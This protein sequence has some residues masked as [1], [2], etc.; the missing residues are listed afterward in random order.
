MELGRSNTL[1]VEVPHRE[2]RGQGQ[3]RCKENLEKPS[4]AVAGDCAAKSGLG[5]FPSEGPAHV[6]GDDRCYD[7]AGGGRPGALEMARDDKE[8]Q[9]RANK[10]ELRQEED[11]IPHMRPTTPPA[12]APVSSCVTEARKK[13]STNSELRPMTSA[14]NTSGASVATSLALRS[15]RSPCSPGLVSPRTTR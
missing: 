11:Q 6:N 14:S 5:S 13:P 10:N 15:S 12:A 4:V 1:C 7:H 8:H 9:C 2:E 3:G